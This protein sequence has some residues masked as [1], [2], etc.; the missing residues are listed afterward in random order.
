[1][2]LE[3]EKVLPPCDEA[4]FHTHSESIGKLLKEIL[5]QQS[6]RLVKSVNR[7]AHMERVR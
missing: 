3:S 6:F 7:L 4:M 1:L 2:H 5:A